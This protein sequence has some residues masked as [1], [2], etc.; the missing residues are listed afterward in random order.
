MAVEASIASKTAL[1]LNQGNYVRKIGEGFGY[2]CDVPFAKGKRC[3]RANGFSLH[4]NAAI[5]TVLKYLL[6]SI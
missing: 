1:N 6:K 2:E 3:D 5:N 4:V